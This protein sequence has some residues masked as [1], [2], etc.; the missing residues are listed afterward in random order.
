MSS[1]VVIILITIA[2]LVLA[3]VAFLIIRRQRYFRALRG[4]G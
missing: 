4:R 1:T 3:L 2:V